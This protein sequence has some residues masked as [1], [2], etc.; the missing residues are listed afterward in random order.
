M[1]TLL[2]LSFLF[3]L[4]ALAQTEDNAKKEKDKMDYGDK[5]LLQRDICRKPVEYLETRYGM[6]KEEIQKQKAKCTY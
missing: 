1:K 4:N 6:T 3:S 5:Q 2:V